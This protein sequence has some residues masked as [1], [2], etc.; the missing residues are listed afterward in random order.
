MATARSTYTE[1]KSRQRQIA[2]FVILIV[3]CIFLAHTLFGESGILVNMRVRV[4]YD[5][6]VEERNLLKR[7]NE[8]L[9]AEILD[10]KTS[11]RKIEELGRREF[12]FGRP[13]EVVFFFPESKDDPI[14]RS[15][16]PENNEGGSAP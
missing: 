5:R 9:R 13:G 1:R 16:H 8:R 2:W 14:Q 6:L 4:E 7:E 12:G 10:L 15:F 11:D 3:G